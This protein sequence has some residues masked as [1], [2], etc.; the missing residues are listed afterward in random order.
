MNMEHEI[1]MLKEEVTRLGSPNE[2]E[3][4]K[5]S[6]KFGVLVRDPRVENL[7][8]AL[9]GTLRS[10]KRQKIVKYDSEMLLQGMS[11]DIDIV[12]LV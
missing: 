5:I 7:C 9:V 8:E 10:A 12:L 4:G 3:G 1:K 11:D 2:K 6:V